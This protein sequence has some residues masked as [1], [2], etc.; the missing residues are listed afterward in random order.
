MNI[1]INNEFRWS[2]LSKFQGTGIVFK[3]VKF[4]TVFHDKNKLLSTVSKVVNL[5]GLYLV[6]LSFTAADYLEDMFNNNDDRI[7]HRRVTK[8]QN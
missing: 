1:S 5:R 4:K 3:W 2:I 7:L 6:T 8:M